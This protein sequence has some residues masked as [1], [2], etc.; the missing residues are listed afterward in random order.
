[1]TN[2]NNEKDTF[3]VNFLIF[4]I[5]VF[6]LLAYSIKNIYLV[7]SY[8]SVVLICV[9][10]MYVLFLTNNNKKYKSN[11]MIIA[12]LIIH[13]ALG[14]GFTS[15][16][17]GASLNVINMFLFVFTVD[18]I[19]ISKKVVKLMKII[20]PP[21]Y[22]LFIFSNH[23]FLNPNYVGFIYLLYFMLF[24]NLYNLSQKKILP[25]IIS[26][27]LALVTIHY[28]NVYQCRT[29]QIITIFIYIIEHLS[30]SKSMLESGILKKTL[31]Y[32]FTIGSLLCTYIYVYM[33]KNNI[34]VDLTSFATK[35][36]YS[37]RNAI[38]YEC[39]NLIKENPIFGVGSNYR[40]SSHLTYALHNSMMMIVTTF[41]VPCMILFIYSLRKLIQEIYAKF[42]KNKNFYLINVGLCCIFFVDYF[43]SYFYWSMYN[44]IEFVII[45]LA[46][47]RVKGEING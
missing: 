40:I 1:M 35:K 24:N 46:I 29:S 18:K 13:I 17:L 28:G 27:I 38:W 15:F 11:I 2:N 42:S 7:H 45:I 33:W 41:G 36:L 10:Y 39:Y 37:G 25:F 34:S 23:N 21:L 19:L 14:A 32:V 43:E 26:T 16:G 5:Y 47:N 20:T 6:Y 8:I 30:L 9:F 44:F 12:I 31:P 3:V 22:I 4:I